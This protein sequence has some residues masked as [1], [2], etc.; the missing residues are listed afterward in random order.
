MR[1]GGRIGGLVE[2]RRERLDGPAAEQFIEA[3]ESLINSLDTGLLEFVGYGPQ[4][5]LVFD[6]LRAFVLALLSFLLG[7][8][9]AIVYDGF[10]VFSGHREFLGDLVVDERAQRVVIHSGE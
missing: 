7:T 4:G 1:S 6:G 5:L 9:Y 3:L 2:S 10:R 8:F